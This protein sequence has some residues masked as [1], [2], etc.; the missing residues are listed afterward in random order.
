LE[1]IYLEE[2]VR[3]SWLL[4]KDSRE[5][6]GIQYVFS[7]TASINC[8]QGKRVTINKFPVHMERNDKSG[9]LRDRGMTVFNSNSLYNDTEGMLM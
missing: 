1:E 6:R 5:L 3:N 2:M 4:N 9:N 7:V 8:H